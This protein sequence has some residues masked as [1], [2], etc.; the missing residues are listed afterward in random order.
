M[1]FIDHLL[2]FFFTAASVLLPVQAA[3]DADYR[4]VSTPLELDIHMHFSNKYAWDENWPVAREYQRLTGIKLKGVAEKVGTNSADLL[5]ELLTHETL[6]DIIGGAGVASRFMELGRQGRLVALNKLIEDHAPNLQAFFDAHPVIKNAITASDG[7][8]YYIPYVPDGQAG[9]GY[10]IRQDWLDKLGLA[11]PQTVEQLHEVLIAFR[12]RDPNGN[13]IKDEVPMFFRHWEEV[14]RLLVLWD[15]RSTGSDTAH[16]FYIEDDVVH[17]GYAEP[18]Y[19]NGIRQI[20]QWYKERLIDRELFTRGNKSRE[21]LLG[22]DR[23]GVIHDWFSSTSAFNVSLADNIPG[24]NLVPI[25]PPESISGKRIEEHGRSPVKPDGWAITVDNKHPIETIKYMDFIFSEKGRNISNFG[26]EGQTWNKVAGQAV[27]TE[28]VLNSKSAVNSQM[29]DVGAQI[30]IGFYQDYSYERQWTN[31]IAMKG[32]QMY[33]DGG[34]ILDQFP[35]FVL[36]ESEQQTYD[37]YWPDILSYMLDM[38]QDWIMGLSD[39]DKDWK[40]YMETLEQMG[41]YKVQKA[42]QASYNRQYK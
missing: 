17:Y 5:E 11:Q 27:F 38:Q 3:T 4:I 6:P 16:Q 40:I 22:N 30:P 32:V 25:A 14:L 15:G 12:D 35:G 36:N 8:L 13:G 26:V 21:I 7:N 42:L 2:L 20:A 9:K 29:W 31:D 23:G 33:I 18:E 24:F 41:F 39:V 1:R 34:Y 19:R 10:F 37:R 28:K